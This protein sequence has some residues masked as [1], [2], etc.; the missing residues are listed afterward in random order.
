MKKKL[1]NW[2]VLIVVF[3]L[4]AAYFFPRSLVRH[5]DDCQIISIL[6]RADTWDTLQYF[7]PTQEKQSINE[8]GLMQLLH[9]SKAVREFI[10]STVIDGIPNEA[11][12]LMITVNDGDK[13]KC[14]ILGDLNCVKIQDNSAK[15]NILNSAS[16]LNEAL[17]IL[18]IDENTDLS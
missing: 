17:H 16:V 10:P 5:P 9:S 18:N 12:T 3:I 2:G 13:S 4:I 7:F 8:E 6:Y 1:L 11:V 14:I 15:Y